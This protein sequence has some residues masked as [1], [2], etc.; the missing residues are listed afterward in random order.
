MQR[1][2]GFGLV[3][4]GV[5]ALIV[6]VLINQRQETGAERRMLPQ[7]RTQAVRYVALGDSTVDGVGATKPGQGYVGQLAER[8]GQTYPALETSNLGVSGATAADVVAGQLEAAVSR[9][10]DLVTLSI[11]PN[12]IIQGRTAA[13]FERDMAV[14]FQR[15]QTET[16]AVVV[17]NLLPDLAVVPIIPPAQ[18]ES[19]RGITHQFNDSLRRAAQPYDI[20]LVDL[21]T[22]SQQQVPNNPALLSADGFH[23]S[24]IGYARWADL[25]W[26]GVVERMSE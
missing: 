9:Q 22:P 5:V 6:A 4:I 25:M 11:G 18:R 10:P 3:M 23:P 7:D 12:D 16:E 24:D 21:Y 14:V 2:L 26:T 8:L 20:T 1:L 19:V 15:L 17:V 13:A